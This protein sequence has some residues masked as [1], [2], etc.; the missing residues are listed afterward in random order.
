M[1]FG[2]SQTAFPPMSLLDA[3]QLIQINERGRQ[4]KS[5]AKYMKDIRLQ[6]KREEEI[7]GEGEDVAG[8]VLKIQKV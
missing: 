6:A 8:A 1:S 2:Q 5:R 7:N 4:G 3:V